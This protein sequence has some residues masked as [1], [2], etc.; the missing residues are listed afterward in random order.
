MELVYITSSCVCCPSQ[1]QC[2]C[3]S[4][5]TVSFSLMEE[6]SGQIFF[7]DGECIV[8]VPMLFITSGWI[9]YS[10]LLVCSTLAQFFISGHT[11]W[12]S[13][14]NRSREKF[15]PKY[16]EVIIWNV[17]WRK[18][19]KGHVCAEGSWFGT[20][21]KVSVFAPIFQRGFDRS[22][23]SSSRTWRENLQFAGITEA[24]HFWEFRYRITR[25]AVYVCAI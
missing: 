19:F 21:M 13:V 23:S 12:N 16:T 3:M 24:V 25:K 20:E 1:S 8:W 10:I 4:N 5:I 6:L 14:T 7:M 15:A 9:W 17:I 22:S 18:C 11:P 2:T